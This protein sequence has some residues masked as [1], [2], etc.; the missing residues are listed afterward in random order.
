MSSFLRIVAVSV[1]VSFF[2]SCGGREKCERQSDCDPPELCL[3]SGNKTD[4]YYCL[5]PCDNDEDCP[6]SQK[7]TGKAAS[8][9]FCMD[10]IDVCE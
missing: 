9:A 8:C 7:C 4:D 10:V 2:I 1:L 6:G 3:F 5:V